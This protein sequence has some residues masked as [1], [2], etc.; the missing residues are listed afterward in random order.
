MSSTEGEY[1]LIYV[2][3]FTVYLPMLIANK[4]KLQLCFLNVLSGHDNNKIIC[5]VTW[6]NG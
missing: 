5:G 2:N 3:L 1:L 6:C 4:T